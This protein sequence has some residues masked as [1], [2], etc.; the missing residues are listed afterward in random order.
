[1]HTT[2]TNT[3]TPQIELN[4]RSERHLTFDH[5]GHRQHTYA[6]FQACLDAGRR[7]WDNGWDRFVSLYLRRVLVNDPP[8]L[9]APGMQVLFAAG[10]VP[11]GVGIL[12]RLLH[13]LQAD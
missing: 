7:A 5:I 10:A 11:F 1:M 9:N 12:H 6:A 3:R 8:P 2:R 4:H 13:H